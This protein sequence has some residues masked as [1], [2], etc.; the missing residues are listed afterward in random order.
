MG[1]METIHQQ[2][3][4]DEPGMRRLVG[5]CYLVLNDWVIVNAA[6]ERP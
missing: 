1:Q 6:E 4:R 5:T 3:R 2:F